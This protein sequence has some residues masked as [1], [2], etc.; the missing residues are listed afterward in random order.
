MKNV[1][2]IV[3]FNR[4]LGI[5]KLKE[6]LNKLG[7]NIYF[8]RTD[9]YWF[10]D[11]QLQEELVNS[12]QVRPGRVHILLSF[13]TSLWETEATFFHVGK[14]SENVLLDHLD[15]FIQIGNDQA[16]NVFLVLEELLQFIDR[17]KTVSLH[18]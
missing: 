14:R 1:L 3:T 18:T 2:E 9:F 10:V 11:Y 6:F 13:N 16:H 5:E 8:D 12:L 7:S 15:N 17:L 4:F